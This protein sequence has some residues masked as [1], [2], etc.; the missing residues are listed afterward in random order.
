MAFSKFTNLDYDQIRESIKDYLRA[1]SNFTGFDFEGSNFSIL[2]DTL[3][4]NAYIN[5]V[6]ANMIVN[7]SFLDSATIRRNV[8]S[9]ASNIG[10]LPSSIKASVADINFRIETDSITPTLT[11]RAGLVAVGNE[12]NS[13]YIFSI[14]ENITTP[15]VGG[16]AEFGTVLEPIQIYQGNYTTNTIVVDGSLDQRFIVNNPNIDYSTLVVRVRNINEVGAGAEWARVDNIININREDEV[17]FLN[18]IEN[19]KYEVIFGDGVF[20]KPV[21][22]GQI[23][24]FSYIVTNGE[25]GNGASKLSFSG[26]VESSTGSTIFPTNSVSLNVLAPSRGG[27]AIESVTSIK[28]YAPKLYSSQ[29]RAVTG[30][31]YEAI[32][33]E[34]YPNMES[35]SVVGGEELV[36]PRFGT[37]ILSIKPMNG[38]SI[39]EFEK[40]NILSSLKQYSVAGINQEIVDVKVL[41]VEV[42]SSVYYDDTVISNSES[43]KSAVS[44]SLSTYAS[45]I[46]LNRFGGRFKYSKMQKVV[47]DTNTSITSNI[48]KVII[49]RNLNA[50]VGNVAQ[51]ELCYGNAF[52]YTSKGYNIKSSG[53]NILG[54]NETLYLADSPNLDEKGNIDGS[55]LGKLVFFNIIS[56]GIEDMINIVIDN[57][58]SIDYRKGEIK[59]KPIQF[60]STTVPGDVIEIQAIPLSNDVLGLKDLYVVFAVEN[61]T[62]NMVKDTITSGEQVSG[63][64]FK[65]TSSY[66]NGK[67]T[68]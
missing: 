67:L 49:R 41:F 24:T 51:Y 52:Y 33:K 68:R 9:L 56:D 1:D 37:V 26:S 57:A 59:I 43:L 8:T 55:G 29:Y 39:S 16:V 23:V 42:N 40:S 64:G 38:L 3:A 54:Y 17:Y 4:Y 63:V 35:V 34:V 2:I 28:Y 32:I 5:S 47:D 11:L 6:N 46:N 10:Y 15:V 25:D 58:G 65:V 14:P 31:D 19:E 30:N 50:V 53:F 20:G 36:P 48:T 21:T 13:N 7:E 60:T 18:E 66:S 45:S 12:N 27:S 62:I 61:S 22:S 44:S